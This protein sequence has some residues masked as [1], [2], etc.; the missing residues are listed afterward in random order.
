[1]CSTNLSILSNAQLKWV[2]LSEATKSDLS[3]SST[4]WAD[5]G[6]RMCAISVGFSS[7]KLSPNARSNFW[8]SSNER[9]EKQIN[10]SPN[11][12]GSRPAEVQYHSQK[13]AWTNNKLSHIVSGSQNNKSKKGSSKAPYEVNSTTSPAFWQATKAMIHTGCMIPCRTEKCRPPHA[14]S[15]ATSERDREEDVGLLLLNLITR[16][17]KTGNVRDSSL[18]FDHWLHCL[19]ER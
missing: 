4:H 13:P 17:K 5:H 12:F 11:V 15:L 18:C 6:E 2:A 16:N 10:D 1:M 19:E 8:M 7:F 9:N 3:L 14:P